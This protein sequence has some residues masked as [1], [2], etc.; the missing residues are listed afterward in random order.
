MRIE[1]HIDIAAPAADVWEVVGHRFADIGSWASAI[2]HSQ[3]ADGGRVCEVHGP[4]A[5]HI[6]EITEALT[7]Y[8]EEARTLTY[9]A[10]GGLPGPMAAAR[11]TWAVHP[12][13]PGRSRATM[14]AEVALSRPW[15][16]AAPAVGLVLR[17]VGRCTLRDLRHRVQTGGPTGRKQRQLARTAPVAADDPPAGAGDL[18]AFA[19]GVNALFSAASGI[20]LLVGAAALEARLGAPAWVL[21][22]VGAGLLAF[23]AMI[24]WS[25]ADARRLTVGGRMAV[26]GDAVW[27][28]GA[29]LL[30][31]AFPEVLSSQGRTALALV[32]VVVAILGALQTVGLWRAAD[33]PPHTLEEARSSAGHRR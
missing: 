4:G 3:S 24:L 1:Q 27:I 14:S 22:A 21:A 7:D 18:L 17:R 29:V 31:A 20:A 9:T 30:L 15:R 6:T 5:V 26:G 13:G 19:M 23:V 12:L 33:Q 2:A 10:A 28:A 32:T 25:L 16:L 8:D 11:N